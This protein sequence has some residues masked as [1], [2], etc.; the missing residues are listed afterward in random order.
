MDGFLE[1]LEEI[2]NETIRENILP[3]ANTLEQYIGSEIEISKSLLD[4]LYNELNHE[5]IRSNIN[6][7]RK[8]ALNDDNSVAA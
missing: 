2:E 4:V 8:L 6:Q 1:Q 7:I 3:I 5:K